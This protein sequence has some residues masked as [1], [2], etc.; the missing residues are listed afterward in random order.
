MNYRQERLT[1]V[2][3]AELSKIIKKE[4]EFPGA[5]VT[6]VSVE[7]T[8]KLDHAKIGFSVFPSEKARECLKTLNENKFE[9]RK[10]LGKKVMMRTMPQLDFQI[11]Y[12]PENA[13]VVE[14]LLLNDQ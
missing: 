7:F 4:L 11:D 12:G 2:F 3:E 6:I 9:L 8:E 10:L 1:K 5:L 13:A 14:K